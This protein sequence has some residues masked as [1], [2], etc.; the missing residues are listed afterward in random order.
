MFRLVS[1][2]FSLKQMTRFYSRCSKMKISILCN[3]TIIENSS[4][5]PPK[6]SMLMIVFF[7]TSVWNFSSG[8]L[9]MSSLLTSGGF[10][11]NWPTTPRFLVTIKRICRIFTKEDVAIL[12]DHKLCNKQ[13]ALKETVSRLTT[14]DLQHNLSANLPID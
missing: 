5:F 1:L 3:F 13:E 12:F 7:V 4:Y 2:L 6:K 14:R 9:E 10:R 8:M 11:E